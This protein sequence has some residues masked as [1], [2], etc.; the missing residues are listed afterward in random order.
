MNINLK[1]NI[2]LVHE[3]T[4]DTLKAKVKSDVL[5][6]PFYATEEDILPKF[7]DL[8]EEDI[9][10][11]RK[12][13]FNASLTV[14][15]LTEKIEML[16][17]LSPT[18]LFAMR[19]DYVICL[20]TLDLAKRVSSFLKKAQSQSK[21]LGDFSVSRSETS[22]NTSI[23]TIINTSLECIKEMNNLIMVTEQER[24][25][26]REFIKGRYNT[27]NIQ[28]N[29]RLW[30]LKDFDVGYTRSPDGFASV[31]VNYK[32]NNYKAGIR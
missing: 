1:L 9:Y 14:N 16:R 12:Q 8:T 6:N 13:I 7:N 23:T 30:W 28:A 27:S 10:Y 11:L 2:P 3:E 22:D 4:G 24:V 26:P 25:L 32:G 17:V 29:D 15:R 21:T 5:L 20:A 18:Q 19:R 31:K